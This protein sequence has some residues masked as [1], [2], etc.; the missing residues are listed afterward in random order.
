MNRETRLHMAEFCAYQFPVHTEGNAWSGR[1]RYLQNC[2]SISVIHDLNFMAHYYN[3]LEAE[4]ENQVSYQSS[5]EPISLVIP[6]LIFLELRPCAIG[7]FR[8]RREN[9]VLSDKSLNRPA[10]CQ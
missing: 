8:P 9:A 4:G 10:H 2:N 3:L 6:C 1:L 5:I 7:F